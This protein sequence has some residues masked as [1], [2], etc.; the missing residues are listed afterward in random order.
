[1]LEGP[2]YWISYTSLQIFVLKFESL[3]PWGSMYLLGKFLLQLLVVHNLFKT[4]KYIINSNKYNF[5]EENV[6]EMLF[7]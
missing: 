3:L 2:L 6:F 4:A 1:M 5:R 7:K